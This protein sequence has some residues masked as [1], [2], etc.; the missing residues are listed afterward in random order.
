MTLDK[1]PTTNETFTFKVDGVE[2]TIIV[3]A[4][5][6]TGTT[7]VTFTESDV[8]KDTDTIPKA[9][10]LQV[11]DTDTITPLKNKHKLIN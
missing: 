8:F 11:V 6:T 2:K 10:D 3:E 4:G 1:A 5:T 7:T 9:T